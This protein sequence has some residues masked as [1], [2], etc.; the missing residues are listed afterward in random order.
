MLGRPARDNLIAYKPVAPICSPSKGCTITRPIPS[1]PALR[2]KVW[3]GVWTWTTPAFQGSCGPERL[4]GES[5]SVF[6]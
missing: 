3:R 2:L 1:T 5:Y 6:V 4:P